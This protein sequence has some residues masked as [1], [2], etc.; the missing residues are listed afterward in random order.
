MAFVEIAEFTG[1]GFEMI[2]GFPL[3]MRPGTY[4]S[5]GDGMRLMGGAHRLGSGALHMRALLVQVIGD[6]MAVVVTTGIGAGVGAQAEGIDAAAGITVKIPVTV[7]GL[8]CM[9]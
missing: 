3:D 4:L 6:G 2:F 5:D 8:L 7:G 9:S 1:G